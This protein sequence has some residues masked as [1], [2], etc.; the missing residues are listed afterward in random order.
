MKLHIFF[1]V[2]LYMCLWVFQGD[3]ALDN[4]LGNLNKDMSKQGIMT[5][6]KGTCGACQKPIVGQ[7]SLVYYSR[8]PLI[9]TNEGYP[10]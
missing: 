9:R 6:P 2:L 1:I 4:M 3:S 5:V 7:V 8:C 10:Q